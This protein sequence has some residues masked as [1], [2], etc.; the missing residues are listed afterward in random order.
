MPGKGLFAS[1]PRVLCLTV[2]SVAFTAL[3]HRTAILSVVKGMFASANAAK[4]HD[5]TLP[6]PPTIIISPPSPGDAHSPPSSPLGTRP[7]RTSRRPPQ[8][9][10]LASP[11]M[12]KRARP[13]GLPKQRRDKSKW[14]P[15]LAPI[16]EADGTIACAATSGTSTHACRST[17]AAAH[18]NKEN[19]RVQQRPTM[20]A[21]LRQAARARALRPKLVYRDLNPSSSSVRKER[22]VASR[23]ITAL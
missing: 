22:F 3:A 10:L 9:E 16:T 23:A 19:E 11:I 21:M 14:R 6:A 2:V 17:G 12:R 7:K 18:D 4:P 15:P 20:P 5:P 8:P 13:R 1:I